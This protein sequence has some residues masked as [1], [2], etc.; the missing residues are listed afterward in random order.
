MLPQLFL[1]F[2]DRQL[3]FLSINRLLP[4]NRNAMRAHMPSET[5]CSRRPA[6]PCS[7]PVQGHPV[8]HVVFRRYVWEQLDV[9]S[10]GM[11]F[12]Q[13][14]KHEAYL[15]EFRCGEVDI[16]YRPRGGQVKLNAPRDGVRNCRAGHPSGPRLTEV[17]GPIITDRKT[18]NSKG[19][20]T[21]PN[22]DGWTPSSGPADH[23]AGIAG[24]GLAPDTPATSAPPDRVLMPGRGLHSPSPDVPHRRAR[25]AAPS[26]RTWFDRFRPEG[27][28][29]SKRTRP[30]QAVRHHRDLL[31]RADSRSSR[32]RHHRV[33]C[34]AAV[35]RPAGHNGGDVPFP[36]DPRR[37]RLPAR[38]LRGLWS[39]TTTPPSPC[40][41][42]RTGGS[43]VRRMPEDGPPADDPTPGHGRT[44]VVARF[45]AALLVAAV[46]GGTAVAAGVSGAVRHQLLLS[47]TRQPD[48]FAELYFPVTRF[49]ADD[50]RG[51]P[52]SR[53]AIRAVRTTATPHAPSP[54]S[55]PPD[56][57]P[58]EASTREVERYPSG[59]DGRP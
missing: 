37:P 53:R 30:P 54:S 18:W 50:L 23:D 11:A 5:T 27:R 59:P 49:P 24:N 29:R 36:R 1:Y 51:G 39:S 20:T 3:D 31:P 25:R 22:G 32:H 14:L 16:E 47:F 44:G 21:S 56:S 6:R 13:E 57:V 43:P 10:P 55:S 17:P 2:E 19:S 33:S 45:L 38:L 28:Q 52:A 58:V 48:N 41:P 9:R 42:R 40:R 7:T 4:S 12:S 46:I 35:R 26:P 34:P 8:R 15:K